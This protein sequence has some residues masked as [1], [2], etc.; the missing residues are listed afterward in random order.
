VKISSSAGR[1]KHELQTAFSPVQFSNINP[2]QIRQVLVFSLIIGALP[3]QAADN[4]CTLK[5]PDA[6]WIKRAADAWQLTVRDSLHITERGGAVSGV[7]FDSNCV[8][9]G[10]PDIAKRGEPHTGLITLPDGKQ[11]PPAVTSFAAPDEKHR[12]AFMVMALPEIWRAGKVESDLTLE[13]LMVAVYVHEMT[14]T[15]QFASISPLIDVVDKRWKLGDDLNDDIVQT[16]FKDTPEFVTAFDAER[17]L[18]FNAAAATTDVEAKSFAR[19]ALA[20]I[21]ARRTHFF[22]GD[23][24]KLAEL[25]DIFLTMEGTAQWAAYKW[26]AHPKGGRFSPEVALRNMRRG[27]R[28]WSQDEG[29]AL[30]LVIDRL[31]PGWTTRTFTDQ[32]ATALTLLAEAAR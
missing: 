22:A 11:I 5:K 10:A 12:G 9:R 28:Q 19:E 25:E 31:V 14:H 24:E 7:F 17:T 27:G 2:M 4:S 8:Y 1:R 13:T 16:R 29:L 20:R 30:Y 6:A 21:T 18:L 23:D 3:A 32:P 15:R 26:V